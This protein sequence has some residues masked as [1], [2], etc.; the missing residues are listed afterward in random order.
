LAADRL[1]FLAS[2]GLVEYRL[3]HYERALAKVEE[4]LQLA[5]AQNNLR[6]ESSAWNMK[7]TIASL[8][9]DLEVAEGYYRLSLEISRA[10]GFRRGEVIAL[11]NLGSACLDQGELDLTTQCE[12]EYLT[13]SRATGNR[14]AEAY[15]PH[16]LGIVALERG[17]YAQADALIRQAL[18]TAL[19]N[20]WPALVAICHATLSQLLLQRWIQTREPAL[21]EEALA[22][23]NASEET[24]SEEGGGEFYA[25]L[26]LATLLSS[27]RAEAQAVIRQAR[28]HA[29]LSLW[30]DGYWL[31]LAEGMV[32]GAPV[33][34]P[35]DW[36]RQHRFMRAVAFYDRAKA[37]IPAE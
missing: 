33:D 10:I 5:Q 13:L 36:F 28:N 2:E 25:H 7:G 6:E 11:Y 30:V 26:A 32:T 17:D 9:G 34:A 12:T 15:A 35:L 14:L 19:Q 4:V 27:G 29:D 16:I 8:R 21:L 24:P 22:A 37:I 3:G 18:Q 20:N 1:T 23:L 31:D